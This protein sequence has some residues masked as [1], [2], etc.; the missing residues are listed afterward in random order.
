MPGK[1]IRARGVVQGVGFRPAIWHLA[2]Q[3]GVTGSV[4]NDGEGVM[5]H[6][7]GAEQDLVDFVAQI[8]LRLPPLARLDALEVEELAGSVPSE[9]QI[10]ASR[11]NGIDTPI[12]ADA[13]TCPDCLAEIADP[14]NRRYRYPF[15]NC[16]HCGP[17]LSIVQSVPYDRQNTSMVAFPMCSQCQQEYDDPA[18]RRFHAQANCCPICGPRLW[19]ADA[20]GNITP[21]LC[22]VVA[23]QVGANSFAPLPD[24]GR[25][26]LPLHGEHSVSDTDDKTSGFTAVVFAA[27]LIRKGLIVAIKGLGGFHLACDASNAEAVDKLRQRKR[28]YAKPFALMARDTTMV[29]RYASISPLELSALQGRA[30]PIVL[31]PAQGELLASGISPDDDKFGFMLPYTPLHTLLMQELDAPIVL[32]SGN[33]SDEPQC[34]DN[35][36][37]LEKLAGIADY[38]LL[39]DRDIVNRLDDSVV[40]LMD[41]QMRMLRRARGYSP[42]VL[43]LPKGFAES[44][45]ILAMGA[46]L[47]NSFCL[48]KNGRA[49]V[50]QHIGDLENAAVQQDYRHAIDLY[51]KLN[52]FRPVKIAVDKHPGYLSTQYGQTLAVTEAAEL[53]SIQHHHAH[54]AACLAEHGVGLDAPP[55]LAAI[56]DGLGMGENSELWG[57]EFLLGDYRS[58]TRLG[59]FQPIALPGGA[60][61]MREPWRNAYAQLRHYFDW[62]ALQRDYADLEIMRLLAGKPL[63][64]LDTM[65]AKNLNS[66]L[67]SSCGRWFD[68]FAAAL[69]L[70]AER[71]DYE[72]QAAIALEVLAAPLIAEE[73][74]YPQAWSMGRSRDLA[75]LSWQGL[76]QAVLND[77]PSGA[78][79][80]RIAVRIHQSLAAATVDV[81]NGLSRQ[82]GANS[83]VLSGGVFQ[84]R[85]L[86]EA[87]SE[88]LRQHG[89]T[90]LSPQRYP[91]NDGGLALGQAAIA[92]ALR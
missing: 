37:A 48:L 64:T 56:F 67:S 35:A 55:V 10:V 72:G 51:K 21:T 62:Q 84:N 59:H 52:D 69:G 63:A 33:I 58:Y 82:T 81:L 2:R 80:A 74:P 73:R 31:L 30:A 20:P 90:V 39:H 83:I 14:R 57:G 61:A 85:L 1:A 40:R 92:A 18:D 60:K 19:L 68:A 24:S 87:V 50:S 36:E 5:V 38:W 70:N 75:V 25:M 22:E 45:N 78:D 66:P 13:A 8:P 28:R 44:G 12:A 89:K 77:L 32:T 91:M 26:N 7:F 43:R 3:H 79:K 11:H 76:W 41:G 17:R 34:T 6:A 16:T 27:S 47:K 42:V 54:L 23:N 15:T 71:V 46:E 86:L 29:S 9:F 88:Q 4:W 49:I 53:V 65:L